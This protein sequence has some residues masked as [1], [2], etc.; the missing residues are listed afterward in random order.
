MQIYADKTRIQNTAFALS[1]FIGV[2]L[3]SDMPFRF[4]TCYS[5]RSPFRGFNFS[6]YALGSIEESNLFLTADECRFTQIKPGFKTL[7]LPCLRL[8]A[9][10]CGQICLFDFALGTVTVHRSEVLTFLVMHLAPV[11]KVIFF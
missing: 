10:I 6:G 11:K 9:F 5:H 8:S 1:A 3:R 4:C 2:H 7:L